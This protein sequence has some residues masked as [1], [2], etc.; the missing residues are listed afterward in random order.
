M[1][2][3]TK[4]GINDTVY[5]IRKDNEQK[6]VKCPACSGSGRIM[7]LDKKDRICPECYGNGGKTISLDLKWLVVG[8]LTIGKVSASIENIESDGDFSNIGSYK[9]GADK[10]KYQYMAYETGIGSGSCYYEDHLFLDEE[11]AQTECDIR[12]EG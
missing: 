5:L 7:L 1:K 6:W 12:N 9:E 8:S 4:F 10:Y 2:I 3:N 11:E